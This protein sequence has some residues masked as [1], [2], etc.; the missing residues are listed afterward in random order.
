M[1]CEGKYLKLKTE[2]NAPIGENNSQ[3]AFTIEAH[4]KL[5]DTHEI[6]YHYGNRDTRTDISNDQDGTNRQPGGRCLAIHPRVISRRASGRSGASP[7]R[8]G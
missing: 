6:V 5:N 7:V 1:V 4:F 2:L 8:T 3:E